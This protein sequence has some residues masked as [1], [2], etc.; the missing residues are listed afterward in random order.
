[1]S[2]SVR[3]IIPLLVALVLPCSLLHSQERASDP[4][5]AIFGQGTPLMPMLKTAPPPVLGQWS[6]GAQLPIAKQ[7]H[8]VASMGDNMY[9]FGGVTA[10]N[11]YNAKSYKYSYTSN[12]W[13]PIADF[14][15]AKDLLS[16]TAAVNGKIYILSGID[17]FSPLVVLKD[18]YKYDPAA[19]TYTKKAP[20]PLPQCQAACAVLDNKIYLIAGING[21]AYISTVQVYDPA[22][23]T[24]ST[25]TSYPVALRFLSASTA[26]NK[27]MATCG[28]NQVNPNMYYIA[29]SYVGELVGGVLT[30]TKV[31]DYP[32]GPTILPTSVGIGDDVLFC[33]G[34]PSIDN[35][36]PATQRAFK[37]NV[38]TDTWTTLELK[39][40]GMQY[41]IQGGTDGRR[42]FVP[43]GNDAAGA[44][45]A[46]LEIL[47]AGQQGGPVLYLSKTSIDSWIKKST[48]ITVQIPIKNN[49]AADLTWTAAVDAGSSAWLSLAKTSGTLLPLSADNIAVTVNAGS[50]ATGDFTGSINL[51]SNDPGHA[52]ASV[53]ITIHA[54]DQDVDTDLNVLIEEGTGTWCQYCPQGADS[55]KSVIA[56][57]PGR[58]Y[59]ISYHGGHAS[60]PMQTPSTAI[61]TAQIGLTGW[62][63]ASINRIRFEGATA[64]ALNRGEWAGRA[65]TL[66]STR[67]A[68]VSVNILSSTYNNATK[69]ISME[70]EV[71]FHRNFTQP[72]RLN[73]AQVQDQMSYPQQ[74]TG[75]VVLRPYFHD[76]VLRQMIPNAFGEVI[77]GGANV[78][79]QTSVKKTFTFASLDSTIG[80]SRLIVF[81][82]VC[83][84][85]TYGEVLQTEEVPLSSFV[86][87]VDDRPAA[88]SFS[89]SQNFP[90]PFNPSTTISFAVPRASHVSVVLT[91]TYGRTLATLADESYAPGTHD[92]VFNADGLASGTYLFTMRAGSFVQTRTMTLVK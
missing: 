5:L 75:G 19:N 1:M 66:L 12:T 77:S 15:V 2:R 4:D 47:D 23:N 6:T 22:A 78:L 34:R 68:P 10:G 31:K 39:P 62:P 70:V 45:L 25:A 41:Q 69:Q 63:Q 73:I 65:R 48:P 72:V 85:T 61:W 58:V 24:W 27:I 59:G 28:M 89:L 91:D 38:P 82:H 42:L 55:L 18:V 36:A 9:I 54:Q 64:I 50:L 92:L 32:I 35:N 60:E 57:N 49:G 52:T 40:T 76:H 16:V 53:Q 90:N 88:E 7:Y 56:Q 30:W 83:D 13:T 67:R 37:Y 8:A 11:L 86:T 46:T 81:A 51:T 84:G 29:D 21:T 79:S 44:A 43:G 33:G 17:N 87:A 74:T 80:T 71:F 20:M 3:L 14:P 26:A